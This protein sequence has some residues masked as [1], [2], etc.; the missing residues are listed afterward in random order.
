MITHFTSTGMPATSSHMKALLISIALAGC[1]SSVPAQYEP[2]AGVLLPDSHVDAAPAPPRQIGCGMGNL[3]DSRTATL[4]PSDPLPSA[5][6]D[7]IQDQII[8]HKRKVWDRRFTPVPVFQSGGANGFVGA[9]NPAAGG[10]S[11]LK[12]SAS[13]DSQFNAGPWEAGDRVIGGSIEMFGTGGAPDTSFSLLLYTSAADTAPV[14]LG[15]FGLSS[16]SAAWQTITLTSF[17]NHILLAT[18]VMRVRVSKVGA[19]LC[20]GDVDLK[21]DRL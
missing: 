21:Y 16:V 9:V 6:I 7:E 20:L 5:L 10:P 17:V 15:T 1:T 13:S 8:G 3:P 2:D 11:I 14:T 12:N 19:N 4:T 18:D